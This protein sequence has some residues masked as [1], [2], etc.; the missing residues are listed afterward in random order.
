[1]IQKYLALLK[2]YLSVTYGET[3]VENGYIFSEYK[4]SKKKVVDTTEPSEYVQLT[5]HFK[6]TFLKKQ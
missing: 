2:K 4:T 1:M 5:T 6:V 3:K